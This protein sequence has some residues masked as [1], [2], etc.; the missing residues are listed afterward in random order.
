MCGIV[1]H[2]KATHGK[3]P[4]NKSIVC[5]AFKGVSCWSHGVRHTT[6]FGAPSWF[7]LPVTQMAVT[8]WC[9]RGKVAAGLWSCRTYL[10]LKDAVL[11]AGREEVRWWSRD[12]VEGREGREG[13]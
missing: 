1:W 12:T 6:S 13:H 2:C 7:L 10:A 9:F 5:M 3:P 11:V 4:R 8:M